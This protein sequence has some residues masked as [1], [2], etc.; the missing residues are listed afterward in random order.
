MTP[1]TVVVEIKSISYQ[2]HRK[3]QWEMIG[4]IVLRCLKD[5][6]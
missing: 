1:Y 3:L 2:S 4:L 6:V 5:M